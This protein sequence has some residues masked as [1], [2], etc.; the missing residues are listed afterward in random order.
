M[1][2][3]VDVRPTFI[4]TLADPRDGLVKYV[5][6]TVDVCKR[7]SSHIHPP[8]KDTTRKSKW[9]KK[10]INLGLRPIFE[11]VDK[12]GENWIEAE[13]AYIRLFKSYGAPLYNHSIGGEGVLGYVRTQGEKDRIRSTL[14]GKKKSPEHIKAVVEARKKSW[15]EKDIKVKE[16]EVERLRALNYCPI[17][18]LKV[19]KA[20]KERRRLQDTQIEQIIRLKY[21]GMSYSKYG[22]LNNLDSRQVAYS[23]Q[24]YKKEKGLI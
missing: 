20:A 15:A 8:D 2:K 4:Y 12:V 6:K 5:G 3:T 17:R 24:R 11:I 21:Y 23:V 1:A 16:K 14:K 19:N 9:V 18:R 13:Q 10:L 7:K 22:R